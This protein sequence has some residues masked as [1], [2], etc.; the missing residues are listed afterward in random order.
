MLMDCNACASWLYR[1]LSAMCTPAFVYNNQSLGVVSAKLQTSF[2]LFGLFQLSHKLT[3]P[4]KS[5]QHS[6]S[7]NCKVLWP[8]M[9]DLR[10]SSTQETSVE[11]DCHLE[12]NCRD[13][14]AHVHWFA[15]VIIHD[16]DSTHKHTQNSLNSQA[17]LS[18]AIHGLWMIPDAYIEHGVL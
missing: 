11:Q 10:C 18:M 15:V 14:M 1:C 16:D 17:S 9:H 12:K 6:Q 5:N 8:S 4:N 13:H 2:H 3:S 7:V